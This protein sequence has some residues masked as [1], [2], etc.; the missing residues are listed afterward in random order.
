MQR[1]GLDLPLWKKGSGS[2]LSRV[3]LGH[4]PGL[5]FRRREPLP[6]RRQGEDGVGAGRAV[7]VHAVGVEAGDHRRVHRIRIAEPAEQERAALAEAGA[8]IL[9]QSDHPADVRL[10]LGR[11]AAAGLRSADVIGMCVRNA[12]K[13]ACISAETARATARASRSSAHSRRASPPYKYSWMRA[14]P[15][16]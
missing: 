11:A 1:E 4:G 13:P 2:S 9:P 5:G 8:A 12:T 7:Q 16:W 6:H 10:D 15:Q 3:V 14:T